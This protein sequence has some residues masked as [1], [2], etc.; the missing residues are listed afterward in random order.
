MRSDRNRFLR[1]CSYALLLLVLFLLS[2]SR[3]TAI[4]LWQATV[5]ATPFLLAAIAIFE[6]PYTAGIFGFFAG[7]LESLH[8]TRVEGLAALY[9]ALFFL[10]FG[11][12]GASSL[13][14]VLPNALLGGSACILLRGVL[15]YVFFYLF[16]YRM[17]LPVAL[18]QLAAEWLPALPI[19][20]LLWFIVRALRRRFREGVEE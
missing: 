4:V 2:H 19:G 3:G 9:L 15:R 7:M 8:S 1:R 16:V 18:R 10:L 11:L 20:V 12:I 17:S 13:R 14:P 6:G 5:D